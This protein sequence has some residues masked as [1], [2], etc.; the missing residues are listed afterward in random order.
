MK[1]RNRIFRRKSGSFFIRDHN[2]LPSVIV[3]RCICCS[4]KFLP[5]ADHGAARRKARSADRAADG[6]E[7]IARSKNIQGN[8]VSR[9]T[10]GVIQK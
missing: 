4:R 3:H 6:F 8:A 1:E 9:V 7:H 2:P 5:S 10:E